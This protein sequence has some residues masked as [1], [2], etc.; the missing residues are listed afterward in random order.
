MSH[1]EVTADVLVIGGGAAGVAA[2]RAAH[3]AG[4]SVAVVA[5][6]GGAATLGSGVVWGAARDPFTTWA[7]GDAWRVGGRYITVAGWLVEGAAGAL[8]SLLDVG[9]LAPGGTPGV[10]DLATH[11]SW[12]PRLLAQTLGAR[13]VTAPDDAPEGQT[14]REVAATFDPEGAAEAFARSLGA[15]CEGLSALLM[16]PVLGLSRFDVATRMSAVLGIPVGE[17]A[18]AA[19]DPPGV[20][21]LRA[22]R[23]WLPEGVTV[24]PD[25]VT[26]KPGRLPSLVFRSGRLVKA[27]AVVVATGGLVGGGLV[28]DDSLR[29]ATADGPVWTRDRQRVLARAGAARGADPVEWFDAHTGRA[30][31]A[32]LR[33]DGSG[34]VLD[35]DGETPLGE[36]LYAAGEVCSGRG[37]DGV[38]DALAEGARVGR[39]AAQ[40]IGRRG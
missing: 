10:L 4:A 36:W 34:R 11:P 19:G 5:D 1:E 35:A 6:G 40:A 18:G 15:R 2:A 25:R 7:N 24:L 8:R 12:S 20:R 39:S 22:L 37:G 23:R 30:K 33:V 17:A 27:R 38:A 32:G 31:G 14:F 16:P 29:E 13:V 3:E 28:F 9:A 26:V 21:A